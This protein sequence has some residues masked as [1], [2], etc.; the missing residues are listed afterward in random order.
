MPFADELLGIDAVRSLE[1]TLHAAGLS[2]APALSAVS[3]QTLSPLTLRERTDLLRDAILADVPGDFAALATL[4]H[5][6]VALPTPPTGWGVWPLTE[7][8]T[9]R[10]LNTDADAHLAEALAL[11]A[12]LTP[13]LTAEFG[14]RGLL[15]HDLP[16]SLEIVQ[17]WTTH[18]DEHVRRLASEGTRAYL[19]WGVRVP[20]LIAAPEA[21]LPIL[22]ALYRDPSEYVRRSVAN[23][24]ND[25]AR[26]SPELVTETTAAWLAAPDENTAWLVKH[27]LRTL[28]KKGD[29]AALAQLGFA[30]ATAEVSPLV[31]SADRVPAGG[32]LG[33]SAMVTNTGS[34]AAKLAIDYVVHFQKANGT[35]APKTFKLVTRTLEPGESIRVAK[36]HSF[37]PITTRRYHPGAHAIALQ[38]NGVSFERAEFAL[39]AD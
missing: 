1:S 20:A 18:P 15:R 36:E 35:L 7:A 25:I 17:G 16:R 4:V 38:V 9:T 19:P 5:A 3:A 10:A 14:I 37:R 12:A 8:V 23:H 2:S 26:H 24:L 27:A 11:Q 39:D 33:F 29:P 34:A 31:L 22:H 28:I 6:A 32:S 13:G 30:P 21:T